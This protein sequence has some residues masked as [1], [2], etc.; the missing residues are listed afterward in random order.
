[1]YRVCKFEFRWMGT[2]YPT[3]TNGGLVTAFFSNLS[4]YTMALNNV[5]ANLQTPNQ[6]TKIEVDLAK[7]DPFLVSQWLPIQNFE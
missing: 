1:M 3:L 4:L 6:V 7:Y 5:M 2:S